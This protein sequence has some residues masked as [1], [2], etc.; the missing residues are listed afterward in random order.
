MSTRVVNLA[1]ATMALSAAAVV[2]CSC[3]A[4][5]RAPESTSSSST[6]AASSKIISTSSTALAAGPEMHL[7]QSA[8]PVGTMVAI[9]VSDCLHLPVGDTESSVFFHDSYNRTK[10]G[11]QSNVGLR[12]LV[13][14]QEADNVVTSSYVISSSD[15]LGEGLFVVFCGSG[16]PSAPFDV[17]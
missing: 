10:P 2:A 4:A 13:R 11:A 7:S 16:G 8:G 1:V 5:K 12:I 9:S 15:S 17:T 6:T 3:G 14:N